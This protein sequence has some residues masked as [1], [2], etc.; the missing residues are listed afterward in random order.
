MQR[1]S[2]ASYCLNN[3]V[4]KKKFGTTA[5][6][7]LLCVTPSIQTKVCQ[8]EGNC[9]FGD[10]PTLGM[11]NEVYGKNTATA[12]AIP[13]LT[14][15]SEYCGVKEKF[16]T[17]QLMQCAEIIA[18]DY[19]Y[20]KVSELLLFFAKF[21]RCAYGRFYGSV[22]PLVIAEALK[23][24]CRERNVAYYGKEQA[25][26]Q[27]QMEESRRDSCSWEEYTKRKGISGKPLPTLHLKEECTTA[28]ARPI[29]RCKNTDV[30]YEIAA[31]LVKNTYRCSEDTLAKMQTMFIEKYR[32]SPEEYISRHK[33]K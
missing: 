1:T 22:D 21:K 9:Y 6:D 12:W 32:L 24:F 23:E 25:E 26:R 19:Y 11:L 28:G 17:N 33:A 4:I 14:D 18:A 15:L 29:S 30:V 16:S 13:Q 7:F 31:A 8:D 3:E 20:L 10:F 2:L 5:K 27:K